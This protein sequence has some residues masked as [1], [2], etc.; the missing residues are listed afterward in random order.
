MNK[1]LSA[2]EL[3]QDLLIEYSSRFM[4]FYNNNK[5]AVWG[6]G[7]A[8]IALITLTIGYFVYSSQQE[9]EAQVL[10]GIAE[11]SFNQGNY[12]TALYGND[13]EFTLGF[14]Q[15]AENYSRTNSGNLANYYAAVSEY[16]LGNYESALEYIQR[17]DP[18]SGILGVSPISFHGIIL[19]ELERYEEAAELFERAAEWDENSSTTPEN[20][21]EAAQAYYETG[22]EDQALEHVNTILDEYPNSH[23]SSNALKL[24]G[25]LTAQS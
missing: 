18:P 7:I 23:V 2:E 12:E 16:E 20:L 19:L 9:E 4:H 3:E 17:F 5:A 25:L 24:K 10:M 1:K 15:I 14:V 21:Y 22:M 6:A 11:Q 8:F 13:A